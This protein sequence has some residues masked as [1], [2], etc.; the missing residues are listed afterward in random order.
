[1]DT[2]DG[3]LAKN[4][5]MLAN[6]LFL[7]LYIHLHIFQRTSSLSNINNTMNMNKK[8]HVLLSVRQNCSVKILI[9]YTGWVF[10]GVVNMEIQCIRKTQLFSKN[11]Q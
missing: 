11:S 10:H 1:M 7:L 8:Q 6:L 3:L 5:Q 4:I 2:I 9:L